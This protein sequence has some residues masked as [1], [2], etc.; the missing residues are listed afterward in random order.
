MNTRK[1]IVAIDGPVGA[2]KTTTAHKVAEILGFMYIDSG[3]MYRAVTLDVLNHDV[4]PDDEEGVGKVAA[5]SKVELFFHNGIQR[6]ILND[7]D[8][9]ERIRDRDVTQ[10]VSAVSAMKCVRERMWILQRDAGKNGG[11][12]MEGRDIGTVVFPEAEFKV[13]LDASIEV[14]AKRRYDELILKSVEVELDDLKQEIIERDRANI[15]RSLAPLKKAPDAVVIDTTGMALEEQVE[16]IVSLV[17]GTNDE[18]R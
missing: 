18:R 2:G 16:A 12:V 14:R 10:A 9:S 15:E 11:I 8:V 4:A 17:S 6:T 5:Q 7:K 1:P 3:A 13:Y